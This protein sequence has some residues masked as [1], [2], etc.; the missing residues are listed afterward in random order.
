MAGEEGFLFALCFVVLTHICVSSHFALAVVVNPWCCMDVNSMDQTTI[1]YFDLR[2]EGVPLATPDVFAKLIVEWDAIW[3][4]KG[5]DEP[6]DVALI[7]CIKPRIAFETV[8][9]RELAIVHSDIG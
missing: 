4:G 5:A 9:V 3:L 6:V 2:C 8:K 1:L 7:E